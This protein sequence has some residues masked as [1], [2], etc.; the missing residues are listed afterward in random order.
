MPPPQ[1][2]A[3]HPAGEVDELVGEKGAGASA[4]LIFKQGLSAPMI[5]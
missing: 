1:W 3:A 2:R 4:D 5:G